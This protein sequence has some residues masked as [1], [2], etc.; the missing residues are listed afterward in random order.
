MKTDTKKKAGNNGMIKGVN[1][2]VVEVSQTDSVYFERIL[3]FVKPEYYGL[4]EAKLKEKANACVSDSF[5]PPQAKKRE[6]AHKGL[7]M[8]LSAAGGAAVTALAALI[9]QFV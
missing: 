1:R 3:F 5:R 8:G 6:K 7:L 9:L 4:G 2:Q